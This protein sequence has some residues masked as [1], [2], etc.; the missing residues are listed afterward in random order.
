MLL[1]MGNPIFDWNKIPLS[2]KIDPGN[3]DI[4]IDGEKISFGFCVNVGNPHI[5]FLMC[6]MKVLI[7]FTVNWKTLDQKLKITN[8]FLKK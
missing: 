3:V 6:S 4:E 2:K 8:F 1:D 7:N 5:I